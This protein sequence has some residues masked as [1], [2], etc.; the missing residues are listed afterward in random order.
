MAMMDKDNAFVLEVERRELQ[1]SGVSRQLRAGG[2]VPAV[3]YG[4][5]LDTLNISVDET[6]FSD[7]LKQKFGENTIFLLKLKGTKQERMAMIHEMQVDPIS[8]RYLHVDFIRITK[9]HKVRVSVPVELVGDSVGVRHGGLIDFQTR[10]V[11]VEVLPR[12]MFEKIVVDISD[13]DLDQNIVVQDILS[14]LPESAG[15]TD[16]AE[17]V[18]VSVVAPRAATAEEEEAEEE[19]ELLTDEESEPEVIRKGRGEEEE[20]E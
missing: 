16:E 12:E 11:E 20:G 14:Q 10:E 5:G 8:R 4:G 3:V 18:I 15:L 13:L 9:G 1:G 19:G 17:R 2:R 7:L 6:D